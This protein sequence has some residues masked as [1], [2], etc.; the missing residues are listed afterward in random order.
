MYMTDKKKVAKGNGERPMIFDI[1]PGKGG[2]G[3]CNLKKDNGVC[4]DKTN[5]V[6]KSFFYRWSPVLFVAFA[7]MASVVLRQAFSAFDHK[8]A[9]VEFFANSVHADKVGGWDSIEKALGESELSASAANSEFSSQNS[10]VYRGGSY[11]VVADSFT[12]REF[13]DLNNSSSVSLSN[14]FVSSNEGGLGVVGDVVVVEEVTGNGTTTDDVVGEKVVQDIVISTGTSTEIVDIATGSEAIAPVEVQEDGV[15]TE[16]SQV[17]SSTGTSTEDVSLSDGVLGQLAKSLK[18]KTASAAENDD[19]ILSDDRDTILGRFVSARIKI[20]LASLQEVYQDNNQENIQN[21]E[22]ENKSVVSSSS[23]NFSVQQGEIVEATSSIS[24]SSSAVPSNQDSGSD[25]DT[26]SSNSTSDA[27]ASGSENESVSSKQDD[28]ESSIESVVYTVPSADENSST[29]EAV[30]ESS[31]EQS[32][33]PSVEQAPTVESSNESSGEPVSLL[34]RLLSPF[35]VRQAKADADA[36]VVI[37]YSVSS[38]TENAVWQELYTVSSADLSNADN[39]G[40]LIF[41]APLVSSWGDIDNLKIKFEGRANQGEGFVFYL[42]AVWVDV[43]YEPAS[44]EEPVE[45]TSTDKNVIEVDGQRIAMEYTDENSD[46]NLIIRTDKKNYFGLSNAEVYFSVE[47]VGVR[48]EDID[49]QFY[50]PSATSGVVKLEKLIKNSPYIAQVPKMEPAVFECANGWDSRDGYYECYPN[51]SRKACDQVSPNRRYCRIDEY[52]SGFRNEVRFRNR[53]SGVDLSNYPIYNEKNFISRLLALGPQEKDVPEN[54]TVDKS[55]LDSIDRLAPGEIRYYK[56][57]IYFA[58]NSEGEFYIE[59]FGSSDGYGLL[60]P[61]WNSGWNFRMPVILNNTAGSETLVDHQ[62]YLQ[63]SS[64][65]ANFWRNIK[66][67]GSDIRFLDGTETVELDFWMQSF[68]HTAS[69]ASFWVQIPSVAAA[70]S[71]KIYVY[72]GNSSANSASSQYSPFT[73]SSVQD[74]YHVVSIATSASIEVVSLINGNVV[75]V[76]GGASVN[77]DRQGRTSFSSYTASSTIKA[78]GPI[79]IKVSGGPATAPAIPVSFASTGFVLPIDRSTE[80]FNFMPIKGNSTIALRDG[81][82]EEWRGTVLD[83][84]SRTVINDIATGSLAIVSSTAPILASL[85]TN[86]PGD[87]MIFYPPSA[88]DLY[89]VKSQYNVISAMT[90]A[91]FDILCSSRSSSSVSSLAAGARQ[92]NTVCSGAFEGSGDAVRLDVKTGSLASVQVDDSDGRQSTIFLPIKEMGAEYMLPTNAAYIATVCPPENGSIVLAIYDQDNIFVASSTCTP[93]SNRYPGKLRFGADDAYTY[94]AGTRIVSTGGRPFYAY[95][96]DIEATGEAGGDET[97]LWGGVQGKKYTA[98]A[99]ALSLGT[100]EIKGPPTG[101]INSAVKAGNGTGRIN[102][103]LEIDDPTNDDSRAKLEYYRDSLCRGTAYDVTLSIADASTTADFGDPKIYNE[104][105][106]QIGSS[107]G[108]IKTASGSNTV[109]TS[110]DS[111][112]DVIA[113]SGEYCLKL[114]A[115]DQLNDQLAAATT[116]LVVDNLEPTIP[117]ALSMQRK[118]G[119]SITIAFGATTSDSYFRQYKIYYK[120]YDGTPADEGDSIWASSSDAD[121]GNID[122]N[123]TATTTITGLTAGLTYSFNIFAYDIGG[124]R[125]SSTP[126]SITAND[127]PTAYFNSVQQKID[128]SGAVDISIEVDDLNNDNTVRARLDYTSYFGGHCDFSSP[129]DPTIDSSNVT[130]DFGVV[131]IDNNETYQIGT[132]SYFI[133]TSSPGANTVDFDWLSKTDVGIA[134]G[135]YCLRLTANDGIDD[136]LVLATT[137]LFIDNVPPNPSGALTII[138]TT[139]DTIRLGL[140]HTQRATDDDEPSSNAY[141]AFYRVG[142]SGVVE[143]DQEHDGVFF[144]S[145]DFSGATSTLVTGLSSNV[146]YVFNIW[147]YDAYGN[148]ASSSEVYGSTD[149]VVTNKGLSFVDAQSNGASTSVAVADGVGVSTFRAHVQNSNGWGALDYV[150]LRLADASDNSS[151]FDDLAFKWDRAG[152]EFTEVGSDVFNSASI[153]SLS[154]SDCADGTCYLYFRVVFNKSFVATSTMYSAELYSSDTDVPANTDHNVYNNV[155][156]VKKNWLDQIHYRWR[157]DDG[158]G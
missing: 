37:W 62:I 105:D 101:L 134:T 116:S 144:D 85:V 13:I 138:D 26:Q 119:S 16:Q 95:Y 127:S 33:E 109:F 140:P 30:V 94:A 121:L 135:T 98:T 43:D 46:E 146:S 51:G 77:L 73:Y 54:L 45:A 59:A 112:Q 64:T 48:D 128:G 99:V 142:I 155:F 18:M 154:N 89:G 65:S 84:H 120:V 19:L 151:P 130:S 153:S 125:S 17:G 78:R 52:Q 123:H 131:H 38:S 27:T 12:T 132:T 70:S 72:Y 66:S 145:Y 8:I 93:G 82:T 20:S 10:A 69:S 129:L 31:V 150:I 122:F 2:R 83:K 141:R 1:S 97:N 108:W 115:N 53:W 63:I 28:V 158:G 100:H 80:I 87:G 24:E 126:V 74:L 67:D 44:D 91:S 14:E 5:D 90:S 103:S 25:D 79:G 50:F 149:G 118:T 35:L 88:D 42:D 68:D 143:T 76:D 3:V 124:N 117:G 96:E 113:T 136:Q 107:T 133:F 29:D 22:S 56:A 9:T 111:K 75:Q 34:N 92:N 41:T 139:Y 36:K 40:Y 81:A 147:A 106:Y 104:E 6:K 137:S 57:S 32:V 11:S 47:N 4:A 148:K 15:S 39:G 58:P 86:Y 60:D 49:L 157:N 110:W 61:W 156:Q 7:L 71:T 21:T 152:D 102:L 114:T 55:T 23:E